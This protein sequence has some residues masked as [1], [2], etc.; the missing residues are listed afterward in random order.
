MAE[1]IMKTKGVAFNLADPYQKKMFEYASSF[2]NFSAYVKRLIQ[3]DMEGGQSII[4]SIPVQNEIT[5]NED[6]AKGFI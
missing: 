2:P 5:I 3:R 4:S 1:K 6:I